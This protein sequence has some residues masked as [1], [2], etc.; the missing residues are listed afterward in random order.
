MN[1]DSKSQCHNNAEKMLAKAKA[2][3]HKCLKACRKWKHDFT[4]IVCSLDGMATPE[5]KAAMKKLAGH[6]FAKDNVTC[7]ETLT[8]IQTQIVP[9]LA[10]ETSFCHQA[11]RNS[12]KQKPRETANHNCESREVIPLSVGPLWV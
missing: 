9:T 2:K 12:V 1:T 5:A 11:T 10:R 4:P 7:T 3:K 8:F 6:C